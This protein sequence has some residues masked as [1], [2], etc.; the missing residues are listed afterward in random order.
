VNNTVT[1]AC[2]RRD[3]RNSA[4]QRK[5]AIQIPV[6]AAGR[7]RF[8]RYQLAVCLPCGRFWRSQAKYVDTLPH[9]SSAD[10]RYD[11]GL[12]DRL[13][14]V[15]DWDRL[16]LPRRDLSNSLTRDVLVNVVTELKAHSDEL[17]EIAELLGVDYGDVKWS[18]LRGAVIA[19]V[20]ET[21]ASQHNGD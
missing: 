10:M 3:H 4:D 12:M 2:L 5:I 1:S 19:R 21:L 15:V 8:I 18:N 11:V 14:A 17:F 6:N 13:K 20:R 16:P 7:N 9:F